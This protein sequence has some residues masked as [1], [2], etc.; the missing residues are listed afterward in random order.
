MHFYKDINRELNAI[1]IQAPCFNHSMIV[2]KYEFL[3]FADIRIDLGA[4]HAAFESHW[5]SIVGGANEKGAAWM[6]HIVNDL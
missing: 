3:N 2:A 1:V 6:K 5:L 4:R